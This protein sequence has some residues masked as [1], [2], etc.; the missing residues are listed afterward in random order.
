MRFSQAVHR[1]L[2]T[3]VF[4]AIPTYAAGISVT[5]SR[6]FFN[7]SIGESLRLQITVPRRGLLTALVLDR[8]GVPVRS[9]VRTQVAQGSTAVVWDG[10]DAHGAVVPDEAYSFKIDLADKA[11]HLTYFPAAVL[12]TEP[13]GEQTTPTI[14]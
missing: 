4:L 3:C 11:R 10:K 9:L 7:P 14:L 8:D 1:L 13:A 12:P 6:P 2:T 5:T